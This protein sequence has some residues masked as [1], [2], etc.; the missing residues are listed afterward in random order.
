M[1]EV[2]LSQDLMESSRAI[3]SNTPG[4]FGYEGKI[5]LLKTSKT[6]TAVFLTMAQLVPCKPVYLNTRASTLKEIGYHAL[7]LI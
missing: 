5:S 7:N 2:F 3:G 4:L 6:Q 1:R